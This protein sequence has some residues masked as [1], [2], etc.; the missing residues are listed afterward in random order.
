MPRESKKSSLLNRMRL[1]DHD[2]GDKQEEQVSD[3]VETD[4]LDFS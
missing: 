4:L 2:S 3:V 1:P